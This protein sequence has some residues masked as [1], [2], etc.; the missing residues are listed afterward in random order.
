M[1]RRE[2]LAGMTALGA[3]AFLPGCAT[4]DSVSGG[5]GIKPHRI[6]IHHHFMS[7]GFSA[8]LKQG[9]LGHAK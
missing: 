8:A 9:G 4:T 2:F 1:N 6:D 3:S 5:V 7:P